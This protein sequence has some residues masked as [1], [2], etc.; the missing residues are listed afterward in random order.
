MY[1]FE[2]DDIVNKYTKPY[3]GQ[4]FHTGTAISSTFH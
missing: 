1:N 2:T 3:D 4:W